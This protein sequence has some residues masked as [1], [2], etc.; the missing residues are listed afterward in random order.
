MAEP[1]I[2]P[3]Q[4]RDFGGNLSDTFEFIRQHFKPLILSFLA[5]AGSFILL[6]AVLN[7]IFESNL[8]GT[9]RSLSKGSQPG[10]AGVAG[11]LYASYFSAPF[12]LFILATWIGYTAMQ[13]SVGAYIK[14]VDEHEGAVPTI[15]DVWR[16]FARYYLRVLFYMIPVI[17]LIAIG[18]MLCIIP[19]ILLGVVLVPLGWVVMME[20]AGFGRAL[21]RCFQLNRGS[22]WT[23]LGLYVVT[24]LIYSFA[25]GA[26][27]LFTGIISGLLAYVTTRDVT[28]TVG[29]I[30]SVVRV[31]GF[32][33]YIIFLVSAVL[34]YYNLVERKDAVGLTKRIGRIGEVPGPAE[35]NPEQS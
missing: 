30:T 14:Y 11:A 32:L 4:I 6:M 1:K 25:S 23:S 34:H 5:I 7:G 33:F 13:V 28:V 2:E 9:L 26:V 19:G 22:F 27:G 12:L 15:E 8:L 29:I 24:T 10:N 20:D 18:I 3:R 16:I 31:F 35:D 17:M 21:E